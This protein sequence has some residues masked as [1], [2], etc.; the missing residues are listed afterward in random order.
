MGNILI[1]WIIEKGNN[2]TNYQNHDDE[3]RK[4]FQHRSLPSVNE[5]LKIFVKRSIRGFES[6]P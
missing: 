2:K 3:A 6:C 4:N 1:H 5:D